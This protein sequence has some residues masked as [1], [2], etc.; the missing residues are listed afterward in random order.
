MDEIYLKVERVNVNSFLS[1]L[2]YLLSRPQTI[3]FQRNHKC[4]QQRGLEGTHKD[5]EVQLLTPHRTIRKSNS[6]S[7]SI[8][9]S[10]K[11]SPASTFQV[12]LSALTILLS[13]GRQ[14]HFLV[15]RKFQHFKICFSSV[16]DIT[17]FHFRNYYYWYVIIHQNIIHKLKYYTTEFRTLFYFDYMN[18]F[19]YIFFIIQYQL[20]LCCYAQ[21]QKSFV[22]RNRKHIILN[23]YIT[24]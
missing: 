6:T 5:H 11:L 17:S 20:L 13:L 14:S 1:S 2:D 21:Y 3:Y 9:F 4:I 23:I 19:Y 18:L 24:V 7:E 10:F 15:H 16:L 12:F 8:A 22:A